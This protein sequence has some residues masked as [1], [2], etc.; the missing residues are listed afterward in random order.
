M[1]VRVALLAVFTGL[2][3]MVWSG[4]RPPLL[5]NT[6]TPLPMRQS[7]TSPS[8]RWP[9][10]VHTTSTLTTDEAIPLPDTIPGG[11][12]LVAD[13]FG[14]TQVCFVARP[15]KTANGQSPLASSDHY[16]VDHGLNRWHF[17]RIDSPMALS[18]R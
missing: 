3:V 17:I 12:Y 13:R 11:S 2:F 6:P 16:V 8:E 9:E 4:D 15:N 1:A 10:I 5:A 14:K 7:P 18:A